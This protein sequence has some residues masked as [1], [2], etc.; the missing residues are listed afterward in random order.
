MNG[1]LEFNDFIVLGRKYNNKIISY[2]DILYFECCLN[3]IQIVTVDD[4]KY[5]YRMTMSSLEE[6]LL[7][8]N[9]VRIHS[10]FLVSID[11]IKSYKKGTI[12]L[13]NGTVLKL[14]R[15]YV[16]S[17]QDTYLKYLGR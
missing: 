16:K 3:Y 7:N 6:L 13:I 2:S 9:F 17:F 4:N 1:S 12:E 5:L 11:K 8:Y 15:K 14:S 10:G